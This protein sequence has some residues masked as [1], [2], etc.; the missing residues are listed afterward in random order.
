MRELSS[1]EKI[2]DIL[3]KNQ[4]VVLYF[5]AENCSV[6]EVLKPKIEENISRN[7]PKIEKIVVN[8]NSNLELASFFNI[9]SSPTI[10][11][12]LKA[13]SLKDITEI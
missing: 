3:K 12:F 7:F 4:A 2:L 1:K 9:F 10:L 8:S 6:C 11:V 5:K 13:K